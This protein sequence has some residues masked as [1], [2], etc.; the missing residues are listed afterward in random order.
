MQFQSGLVQTSFWGLDLSGKS[1]KPA[2][3]GDPK[4]RVG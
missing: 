2:V 3:L 4:A 1:L